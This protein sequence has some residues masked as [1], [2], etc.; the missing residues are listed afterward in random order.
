[1]RET[2]TRGGVYVVTIL[3][4]SKSGLCISS[5]MALSSGTPV[6]ILCRGVRIIGTV[7]YARNVGKDEFHLGVQAA[8]DS[9][10]PRTEE[11][12]LDLT[13]LFKHR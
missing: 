6:D 9:T 12:E 2:G 5:S 3:D 7:R 4:V 11:G 10:G 8:D 1:M 13:L